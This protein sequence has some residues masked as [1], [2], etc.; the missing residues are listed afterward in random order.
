MRRIFSA[1]T[2]L[3]LKS[4]AKVEVI[5][6]YLWHILCYNCATNVLLV[7]K[8]CY[9]QKRHKKND[10]NGRLIFPVSVHVGA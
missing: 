4:G 9:L 7:L 8:V 1:A 6:C 5:L 3:Q 10:R 2:L